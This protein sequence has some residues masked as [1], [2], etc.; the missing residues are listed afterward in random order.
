[1]QLQSNIINVIF[2]GGKDF[3]FISE[4]AAVPRFQNLRLLCRV[5]CKRVKLKTTF[6]FTAHVWCR[7][8]YLF[9]RVPRLKFVGLTVPKDVA[10]SSSRH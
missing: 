3:Y 1:M 2:A 10:D 7:S 5:T 8:S 4:V 9:I 6:E